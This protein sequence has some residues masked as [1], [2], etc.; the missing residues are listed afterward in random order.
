MASTLRED[1]PV[2]PGPILPPVTPRTL[3][4][5]IEDGVKWLMANQRGDGSWMD[6]FQ[7]TDRDT[8]EAVVCIKE[9]CYMRNKI[10][11]WDSSGSIADD[12]ENIDYLSR[13]IETLANS[14]QDVSAL[15]D[16]YLFQSRTLMVDGEAMREYISNPMDT[17]L[18]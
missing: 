11:P 1:I 6:L 3:P 9:F 5:N 16:C 12:S 15:I 4:P 10:I 8:A 18:L 2:N 14:G 7:T 13:K 17:S